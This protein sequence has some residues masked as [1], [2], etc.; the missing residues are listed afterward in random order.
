MKRSSDLV[1]AKE[2]VKFDSKRADW[3]TY[4]NFQLMYQEVYKEMDSTGI[5][6]KLDMEVFLDKSG[7]IV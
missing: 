5:A 1:K 7:S 4:Q 2:G 3:C 6:L